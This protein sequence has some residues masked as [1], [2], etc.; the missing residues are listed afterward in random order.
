MRLKAAKSP[1]KRPR[2]SVDGD[3]SLGEG[4][5][6][7]GVPSPILTDGDHMETEDDTIDAVLRRPV[8][9]LGGDE[10]SGEILDASVMD[11]DRNHT[12]P[13]NQPIKPVSLFT[14]R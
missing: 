5:A 11:V 10:E 12:S 14:Q 1:K 13:I 7:S 8:S 9:N 4:S 3:T 2:V 6:S